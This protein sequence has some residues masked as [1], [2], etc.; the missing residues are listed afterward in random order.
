MCFTLHITQSLSAAWFVEARAFTD[1]N[2]YCTGFIFWLP[3]GKPNT[4]TTRLQQREGFNHKAAMWGSE[5]MSLKSTSLKMG[6]QGFLWG[7]GQGG[8]KCG[9]RWLEVRSD[10]VIND[11]H[12]RSHTPCL[13]I[14]HMFTKRMSCHDLRVEFSAFW[15][16]KVAYRTSPR[17]QL[18]SWWSQLAWSRQRVLIPEKQLRHPLP[19][20]PRLQEDIYR[21]IVEVR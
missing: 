8:L 3:P 14:R 12:K 4:E 10:E 17:A 21:S 2:C 16:Q 1:H 15:R 6:T 5:R 9:D 19:W 20:W 11:L 7:K 13:F 18:M